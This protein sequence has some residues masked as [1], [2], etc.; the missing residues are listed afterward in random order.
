MNDESLGANIRQF[1]TAAHPV[2]RP[3]PEKVL[4][5]GE[6]NFLRGFANWMVDGL[7]RK[8]LFGGSVVVVQP[9]QQGMA[10]QV[11]QQ[12]G[13]YTLL[14][15]GI[16]GGKLVESRQIIT[17]ISRALNP[18]PQWA[19]VVAVAQSPDLR[20]VFSN[21]TEAG[22]TYTEEPYQANTCPNT[23]PAKVTALLLERFK[24]FNG[25]PSKGLVF[26]P[27]ELIEQNGAKLKECVLK[28]AAA[29]QFGADF[30]AWVQT[31]NYFL[32]TLVDRIVPGYPREEAARLKTELGYEDKLIV[33]GEFFHLWVIEGPA[34]LAEEIPFHKAGLNVVWTPDMTPYRSRKVRV[35]NGAHTST[36]LGAFLAGLNTVGEM[37]KD[38]VFGK[39]VEQAVFDEIVPVLKMEAGERRKYAEAVL[40]RFNNPFIKHEL[41]S[42]SLNSVSKWKVR[43]LPS[44]LDYVETFGQLPPSLTFSLAALIRFYD[45]TPVSAR[46]L[47]GLRAGQPYPIRDDADIL[48]FFAAEWQAYHAGGELKKLVKA[49]LAN[50]HFWGRD[51][52][53]IKHFTGAVESHLK[54]LVKGQTQPPKGNHTYHE[55]SNPS[56]AAN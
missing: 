17:S 27:C 24:E 4:Q 46:E 26:M 11:Q 38:P 42:I 37:M 2:G 19:E 12:A 13:L 35:L 45:G 34:E 15:R 39:F 53:K 40:E 6:G 50:T 14:L 32:N 31:A 44:L 20:F 55:S 41:L 25:D 47:R 49:V 18:Y 28:Y 16:Q 43:V 52:T 56:T 22:I 23:F 3:F 7:N 30:I 21:T 9:I 1:A 48:A 5:F 10:E 54:Q 51:L 36:V 8:G 29:W 33:A